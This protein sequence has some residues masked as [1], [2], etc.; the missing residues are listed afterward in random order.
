MECSSVDFPEPF[1]PCSMIRGCERSTIIGIWK[2]KLANTGCPRIFK[3][4]GHQDSRPLA[5]R[6][7]VLR[8]SGPFQRRG[9]AVAPPPKR[10]PCLAGAGGAPVVFNGAIPL[11][12]I[13]W[14]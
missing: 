12:E 7:C 1:S 11:P 2:F 3:Y 6:H 5:E 10:P 4:I 13:D 9:N 14:L 8:R